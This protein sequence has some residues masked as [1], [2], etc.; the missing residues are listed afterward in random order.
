MYE[1]LTVEEIKSDMLGRLTTHIKT[2]EG[3]FANDMISTV[4]YEVWKGLQSLDS[5]LPISFV[6]ETSGEYIDKRCNEY[7]IT[8]KEGKK[9]TAIM[10]IS[11]TDDTIIESGKVFTTSEGLQFETTKTVTITNGVA[12]VT[13]TAIEI[14]DEY[15]V[16]ANTITKQIVS[17]SGI[18]SVTNEPATGGAD[19]ESDSALVKRLYDYLQKPITS[20]NASHYKKWTLEVSGVGDAKVFPIWNG[21]GT[22][23][24]L[25]VGN[26]N[27]PVDS[28]I[29]NNCAEYIEENRPIGATVTVESAE[30][31]LIN[32]SAEVVINSTTTIE[33]VTDNFTTALNK[34]LQSIAFDKYTLVY[35]RIAY[36]LLDIDGVE[37]YT[38]LTI[39]GGTDNITI[40]ENQVPV[41][42]AV[43]VTT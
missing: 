2:N 23:K 16:D 24:I 18:T 35:N 28:V 11:G 12:T 26:D 43:E 22:V 1:D 30:G 27:N 20:G 21:P 13:A 8:R 31:L 6:D 5:V 4:A 39:N 19:A 37:D 3:S 34:H 25:I 9:A 15:N 40:A 33:V 7:G 32:I 36:M 38:S 17:T 10:I 41:V 42:G 29:V 14:G